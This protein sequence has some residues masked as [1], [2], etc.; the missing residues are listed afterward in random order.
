M[1]IHKGL[2]LTQL[3]QKGR[4]VFIDGLSHLFT[5][6]LPSQ[7]PTKDYETDRLTAKSARSSSPASIG[8]MPL[9]QAQIPPCPLK[10]TSSS[11]TD[12]QK[13][14]MAAISS[15]TANQSERKILLVLDVPS[16][17]LHTT[18]SPISAVDLTNLIL[19]L[20]SLA[21]ATIISLP[22]DK[23]LLRAASSDEEPG[24]NV[25]RFTPLERE[26]AEFCVNMAYAA[27]L[28][29]ACRRLGTGW[30]EDVSGVLRVTCG[31]HTRFA[32]DD[33]FEDEE[34]G[35]R[36]QVEEGEWLYHNSGDGTVK[37]WSRG[38]S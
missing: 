36:T 20:R 1:F 18:S 21:Y 24:G 28:V 34:N 32:D 29:I 3:Q 23:P 11:L 17:L 13:T 2:D 33:D 10:I 6:P 35:G 15:L 4:L 7:P 5:P 27:R 25:G 12:I 9:A 14:V 30:A 8:L 22:A 26:N 37:V 31:G 16:L 38:G 19:R